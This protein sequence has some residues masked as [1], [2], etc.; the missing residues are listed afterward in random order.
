MIL[1]LTLRIKIRSKIQFQELRVAFL[2]HFWCFSFE[3][4]AWNAAVC[5]WDVFGNCEMF[6][7]G[8]KMPV[9]VFFE[10]WNAFRNLKYF[11]SILMVYLSQSVSDSANDLTGKLIIK[12]HKTISHVQEGIGRVWYKSIFVLDDFDWLQTLWLECWYLTNMELCSIIEPCRLGMKIKWKCL[13]YS[14]ICFYIVGQWKYIC[15]CCR[16]LKTLK[17]LL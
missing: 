5:A 6:L 8:T 16:V 9:L 3:F 11:S 17:C 13:M 7:E 12:V 14:S 1:S 15:K 2:L 10:N 4:L